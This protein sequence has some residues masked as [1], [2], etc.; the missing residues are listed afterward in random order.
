MHINADQFTCLWGRSSNG[1]QLMILLFFSMIKAGPSDQPFATPLS[2]Q[3]KKPT[4]T[5]PNAV[6]ISTTPT[7]TNQILGLYHSILPVV[8]LLYCRRAG[9][10]IHAR[11]LVINHSCT[12]LNK[13][14][15][16]GQIIVK[17]LPEVKVQPA[18]QMYDYT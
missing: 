5:F 11:A 4:S 6:S 15:V 17:F 12:S 2:S 3:Y 18:C 10:E 16:L 14:M 8:V 1:G 13:N 7:L 9:F